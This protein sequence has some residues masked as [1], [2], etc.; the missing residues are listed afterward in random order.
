MVPGESVYGEK[1]IDIEVIF[2]IIYLA[3]NERRRN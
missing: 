1:R 3:S 2:F